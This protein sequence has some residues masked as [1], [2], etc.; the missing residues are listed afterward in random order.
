MLVMAATLI[1]KGCRQPSERAR[2]AHLWLCFDR[3]RLCWRE[4]LPFSRAIFQVSW[5]WLLALNLLAQHGGSSKHR[6]QTGPAQYA[7]MMQVF[8]LSLQG[9]R[10]G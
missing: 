4:T 8:Q 7:A 5:K 9:G 10:S 2:P 3:A 1:F 6:P